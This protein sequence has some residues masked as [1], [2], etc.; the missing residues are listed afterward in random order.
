TTAAIREVTKNG[1]VMMEQS[2]VC[3]SG[4]KQSAPPITVNGVREENQCFG[5]HA[6]D[7]A[8]D[9]PLYQYANASRVKA[10]FGEM[11]NTQLRL[12]VPCIVG[13]WGGCSDNTDTSWFPHAFELLDF[14]DEMKWGQ[15]Y[16]DYHGDD[17]DAPLMQ[18]LS[19]T[20]PVAVAGEI[21]SYGYNRETD[22]FSLSFDSGKAG[23]SIVYIHKPFIMPEDV[24]IS[25]IEQYDNGA[26]LIAIKTDAG[27]NR[28][29]IQIKK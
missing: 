15:M 25:V 12:Q 18:M 2:Y 8:V 16:W 7:F 11:R 23:E 20:H 4:I 26:S 13:E 1:I 21:I 27:R 19:R 6:Y 9:T 5:P 28:I 14:F 10:F 22:V 3:N 29:Q 17:M 24:D